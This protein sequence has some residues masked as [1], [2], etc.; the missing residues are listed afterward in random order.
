MNREP[1]TQQPDPY[2]DLRMAEKRELMRAAAQRAIDLAKTGFPVD[3]Q[4]LNWCREFVALNKPLDR[5][6]STGEP[7]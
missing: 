1:F 3:A 4:Y 2:L 7:K 5:P 6:L